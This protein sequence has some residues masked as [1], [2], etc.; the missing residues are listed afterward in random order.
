MHHE[1]LVAGN[2]P[3]FRAV[4]TDSFDGSIINLTGATVKYRYSFNNGATVIKT[5]TITDAVG[6]KATYKF[7]SVDF[8]AGYLKYDWDVVD[9]GLNNFTQDVPPF[10]K[11]V[12]I[13]L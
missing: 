13:K 10:E 8:V 6:G 9:A 4:F 1:I 3:T 11:H 7:P 2:T 5:A 12:R